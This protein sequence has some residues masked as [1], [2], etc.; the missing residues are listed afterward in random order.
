LS[1]QLLDFR[2]FVADDRQ[3]VLHEIPHFQACVY[4][5][6]VDGEK[7]A[8]LSERKS[9]SLCTFH[10]CQAIDRQLLEF[11]VAGC[12]PRWRSKQSFLLVESHGF[13]VNLGA[14][15]ELA[16]CQSFHDPSLNPVGVYRV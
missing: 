4:A 14:L 16:S 5:P 2:F 10:K 12:S 6:I 1:F 3:L 9:Q 7:F 13:R 15:R 11:S 8:Y